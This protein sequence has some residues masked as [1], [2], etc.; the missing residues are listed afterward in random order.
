M[1][2]ILDRMANGATTGPADW[3]RLL[4]LAGPDDLQ[5][6][7]RAAYDVK[8]QTV[9]PNVYL[10]GIIEFSNIC[11]KNCYYCGIRSGNAEV[12]RYDMSDDDIVRSAV[13]A[14][15]ANYGSVVLQSGER[16]TSAFVERVEKLLARIKAETAGELGVTLSLGEQSEEVYR[17]WFQ[18]GA[19]RYLLRI[20]TS[21][22]ALYER[23]HPRDHEFDTRV[24][25]LARLRRAGYQVGTG[26]MCGL[27]GQ[28]T[29]DLARD[30]QFFQAHD[31]DMIG[32]GPYL[33]HSQTPLAREVGPQDPAA[34]LDL[35]LK[36]IAVT[37]LVLRDVNIAATTALQ[38]L[39][40]LGRELGL[41]A[42][43]NVIMPNITDTEYRPA[44]Q[45]YEGKPCLDENAGLCRDCL[46]VRIAQIGE[47]IGYGQWGDSP[48]F[49]RRVE[50]V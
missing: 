26:V 14:H 3:R 29:L 28:S 5:A 10:R 31:I 17:R 27:P 22:R 20:E 21:N 46:G 43:A 50:S 32:M 47:T 30:I 24:E 48:H 33:V 7:F 36:M 4:D 1:R 49:F 45:L 9:G 11:S 19:H 40:P 2:E 23:L 42:G 41:R 13:W 44:Y 35:G 15:E 25:C 8:L 39:A 18:A 37:R 12:E 6:L 16:Q 34:Q 38:A